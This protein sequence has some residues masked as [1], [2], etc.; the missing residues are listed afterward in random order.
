MC[1]ASFGLGAGLL[2]HRADANTSKRH[3]PVNT[4]VAGFPLLKPGGPKA[5]KPYEA[6]VIRGYARRRRAAPA[7]APG[8]IA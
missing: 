8:S 6:S 5:V 7:M 1:R 4:P 3:S 2:S